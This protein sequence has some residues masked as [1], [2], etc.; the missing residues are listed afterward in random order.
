MLTQLPLLPCAYV[1]CCRPVVS[2]A[3]SNLHQTLAWAGPAACD[4]SS[5]GARST[6]GNLPPPYGVSGCVRF[7]TLVFAWPLL[8]L[9]IVVRGF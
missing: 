4:Q 1:A 2:F 6:Q 5:P 8:A 7:R 3:L 9:C